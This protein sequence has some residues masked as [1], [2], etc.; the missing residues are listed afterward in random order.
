[1]NNEQRTMN[2]EKGA[3]GP[4][5]H[6]LAY[7][8]DAGFGQFAVAAAKELVA[9]LHNKGVREGLVVDLGCGS[10]ILSEGVAAAGFDVLG[11][12]LSPA[13]IALARRRVPTGRFRRGSFLDQ[14]L[15]PC[16]AVAAVGEVFNYLFDPALTTARL[17]QALRRIHAALA[18]RGL[19]LF[20]VAGPGRVPGG[21]PRQSFRE[22]DDWTVLVTSEEKDRLLTR[23]IT[24]FRR[25]GRG[26]RRT[27][28][29]HRQHLF[30][31][32]EM[33]AGLRAAGFRGRKLA[34]YGDTRL[35]TAWHAFAAWRRG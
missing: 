6:D 35:P 4:Y 2:N 3:V 31:P 25:S 15:P 16:T 23:T 8:H 26:Y 21:G 27:Q 14:K 33:L 10:G 19:L 22:G 30:T 29:V 18:P 9:M 7:V 1:M 13:M 28:E 17:A 11:I 5:G 34:R 20:D 12:D 32:A 24:T